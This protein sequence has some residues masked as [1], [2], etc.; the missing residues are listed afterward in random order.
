MFVK[1]MEK[2]TLLNQ[3]V[4]AGIAENHQSG[5]GES[6]DNLAKHAVEKKG[7]L[8]M[9]D[10]D[11]IAIIKPAH[12]GRRRDLRH[13]RL[14][15]PFFGNK[16]AVLPAP[17]LHHK[18]SDLGQVLRPDVQTPATFFDA[19]RTCLPKDIPDPERL[20]QSILQKRHQSLAANLPD[21]CRQHEG[22]HTV[23]QESSTRFENQR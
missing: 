14:G 15:N 9:P 6:N 5:L 4:V 17:L 1:M 22:V 23:V 7:R 19:Q 8:S 21:N 18:L 20:P 11:L 3:A 13:R 12:I 10:P 2:T 16:L